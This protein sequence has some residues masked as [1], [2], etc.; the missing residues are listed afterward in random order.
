VQLSRALGEKA[1]LVLFW[2]AWSPRSAEALEDYQELLDAHAPHGLQVVA[3]T[4]EHQEW[5]PSQARRIREMADDAGGTYPLALDKDLSVFA[6][7]GF[8]AVPSSILL[9][10]AGA[11]AGVLEG[12]PAIQRHEF[13]A[14]VEQTLGITVHPRPR[15]G[16]VPRKPHGP[17][18]PPGASPPFSPSAARNTSP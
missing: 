6:T 10:R 11:V 5:D 8:T 3:V 16:G 15:S 7:L 1:T 9:D 18:P 13:A 12:Y 17:R 14:Q 2:A 4:V